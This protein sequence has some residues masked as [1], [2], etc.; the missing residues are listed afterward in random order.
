MHN[1]FGNYIEKTVIYFDAS[2]HHIQVVLLLNQSYMSGEVQAIS[3]TNF[4]I[5]GSDP[6]RIYSRI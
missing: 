6:K 1:I 2:V 5:Q 3:T 4:K